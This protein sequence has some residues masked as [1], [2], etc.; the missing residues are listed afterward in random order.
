MDNIINE[1]E[2]SPLQ[3]EDDILQCDRYGFRGGQQYTNPEEEDRVPIEVI[4]SRELKWRK[5]CSN[6]S[7]WYFKYHQKLRD[8]CRKGIPDSFRC[9]AW[10]RLCASPM[11][12]VQRQRITCDETVETKTTTTGTSQSVDHSSKSKFPRHRFGTL[13][14]RTNFKSLQMVIT[15]PSFRTS[16]I[17]EDDRRKLLFRKLH[18][19]DSTVL[20]QGSSFHSLRIS[21]VKDVI[22]DSHDSCRYPSALPLSL[23]NH[24]SPNTQRISPWQ[25]NTFNSESIRSISGTT[26]SSLHNLPSS[27]LN[28]VN[29]SM[30]NQ[31]ALP[32]SGYS[33]IASVHGKSCSP[34]SHIDTTD[35]IKSNHVTTT[36]NSG[37]YASLSTTSCTDSSSTNH[38]QNEIQIHEASSTDSC[39]SIL[40]SSSVGSSSSPILHRITRNID[41]FSNQTSGDILTEYDNDDPRATLVP[42]IDLDPEKLY[43]NYCLQEGTS[44]NCD[45]IRR[46]IDRQ[47]PFHELFSEK[48]GHGQESLYTLLKAYTVRHPEKGYC[49]GQAPLAA[50]LLMFMPEVDAFWTFNEICE[51]YLESYYDDGL[52]RVQID[53]DVLYALLKSIHPPIYKFLRKYSVEPNLVV[54]E[55]FMCA[56]TRTLPWTAVLRIWDLFFCDGKIILFK[57]AIVLLNRLFGH[58][59]HRKSC[60]GLDDILMRLREVSSVVGKLDNFIREV[61]RV[62]ITTKELSQQIVRQS[63]KW[64]ANHQKQ[65]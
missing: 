16:Q 39:T 35:M 33:T 36:R 43:T 45:Q 47:F 21:R 4:R 64:A 44:V 24:E 11:V 42:S 30:F 52:E 2:N 13:S 5:M 41:V 34:E 51:R 57:V 53:G 49:Q 20:S 25:R 55:W 58:P 8:R 48:G 15:S 22:P 17:K 65:S 12:L 28:N 3:S 6:W 18:G 60:Q 26:H 9:E 59:S 56:Y 1:H 19:T 23:Q 61:V 38:F 62:P 14:N 7:L 40:I 10:Q 37:G 27:A 50:V 31:S 54:L 29:S 46:D 32:N 63:Q